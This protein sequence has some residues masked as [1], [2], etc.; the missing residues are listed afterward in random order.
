MGVT[1][2]LHPEISTKLLAALKPN[3]NPPAAESTPLPQV[4]PPETLEPEVVLTEL[5]EKAVQGLNWH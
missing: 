2:V 3:S 5:P 4:S 1:A